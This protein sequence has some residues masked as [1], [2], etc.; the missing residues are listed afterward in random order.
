M[1]QGCFPGVFGN[2]RRFALRQALEASKGIGLEP[3]E[4]MDEDNLGGCCFGDGVPEMGV[5][6]C[7]G[8]LHIGITP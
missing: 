7:D 5:M 3:Q 8:C 4:E 6:M 1:D 2:A